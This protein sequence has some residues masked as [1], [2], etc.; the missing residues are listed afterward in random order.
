VAFHNA[1]PVSSILLLIFYLEAA[2]IVQLVKA[3]MEFLLKPKKDSPTKISL[4]IRDRAMLLIS[5]SMAL[6][7]DNVRPLLLSDLLS[8]DI[9]FVNVGLDFKVKVR[10]HL[11]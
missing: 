9:P 2:T 11:D 3:S 7:G 10:S 6:R 8:K 1:T 5:S 4:E